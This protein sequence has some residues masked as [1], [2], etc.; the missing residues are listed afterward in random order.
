M[1]DLFIPFFIIM[2]CVQIAVYANQ[3]KEF[4]YGYF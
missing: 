4:C 2:Y 1:Y 3:C